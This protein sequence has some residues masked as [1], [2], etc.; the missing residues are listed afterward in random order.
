MAENEVSDFG[1]GTPA[2]NNREQ[3]SFEPFGL[4]LYREHGLIR[5]VTLDAAV[6]AS[7]ISDVPR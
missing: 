3:Y 7:E 6:M 1:L 4:N 5:V 2:R